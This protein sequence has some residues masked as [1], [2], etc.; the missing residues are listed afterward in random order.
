MLYLNSPINDVKHQ[1]SSFSV[2]FIDK[3]L[4][5]HCHL[6]K[7]CSYDLKILNR[8]NGISPNFEVRKQF[9]EIYKN[10][11]EINQVDT[12]ISFHPAAMFELFMPFNRTLIVI[13]STRYELGRHSKEEWTNLNKNLQIIASNPR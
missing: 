11:R 5:G 7:T 10:D 9:Y 1:L 2:R 4:S 6:T 12:F 13:A 3:S 8:Q